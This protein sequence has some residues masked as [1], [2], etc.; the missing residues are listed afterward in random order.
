MESNL[1]AKAD[2]GLDDKLS[3]EITVSDKTVIGLAKDVDNI[4]NRLE[5]IINE[6]KK[7]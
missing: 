5:L 7:D 3:A 1:A 6:Q 2:K 4:A